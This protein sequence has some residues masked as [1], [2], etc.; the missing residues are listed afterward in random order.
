MGGNGGREGGKNLRLDELR[1]GDESYARTALDPHLA[2]GVEARRTC[3]SAAASE[4]YAERVGVA[5]C[6]G[7]PVFDAGV[8]DVELER[9]DMLEDVCARGGRRD[10]RECAEEVRHFGGD[11]VEEA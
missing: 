2:V 7:G 5:V 9:E 4:E 6:V 11:L 8:D 1:C 3:A 10:G